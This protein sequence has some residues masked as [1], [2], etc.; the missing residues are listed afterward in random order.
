MV[1]MRS[2]SLAGLAAAGLLLVAGCGTSAPVSTTAPATS[3]SA[4][5]AATST[6]TSA[7]P[8]TPESPSPSASTPPEQA[9]LELPRG[10]TELFPKY[11][12]FGYSGFPG[13]PGQGRLGIGNIDARMEEMEKRG[14]AFRGGRELLPV[15]ELIATTVHGSPGSDGMFRSRVDEKV[16]K[17]WLA[18]ANKHKALLLL[19]IQPGR[20]DFIDEVKYFAKW[21]KY[22]NVGLALDPEWAVDKGQIPGRVFGHT[23][24]KELDQV[25]KYVSDIVAANN[26][27]EKVVLFHQ[28]NRDVLKNPKDLKEYPGVVYINSVDGIGS[29]GAKTATYKMV[30]KTRPKYVYAGFKLFYVEDRLPKYNGGSKGRLMTAKEVLK[31][32]PQPEYILFE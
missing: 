27:P 28:L 17:N 31:L 8:T 19:N 26:L 1:A 13:A 22:P 18:T 16:I 4:G 6:A 2:H 20:A 15:M 7:S 32:K 24:G 25:A 21:L 23:S 14:Q 10:G 5:G 30:I 3:A 11:R 29:P 9:T 12:L